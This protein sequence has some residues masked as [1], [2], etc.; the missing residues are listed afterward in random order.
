[1]SRGRLGELEFP[2]RHLESVR[3]AQP[4]NLDAGDPRHRQQLNALSADF[5]LFLPRLNEEGLNRS[6]RY[7]SHMKFLIL[8]VMLT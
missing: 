4:A 2:Q 3:C 6:V 1:M 5:S 7:L 8:A